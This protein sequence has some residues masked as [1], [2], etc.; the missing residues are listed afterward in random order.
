VPTIH[1][2]TT[3]VLL[4]ALAGTLLLTGCSGGDQTDSVPTDYSAWMRQTSAQMNGDSD[5]GEGGAGGHLSA[6]DGS[7][8]ARASASLEYDLSGPY[9]DLSGPYDVLAVCRSTKMV[10]LTVRDF[11]AERVGNGEDLHPRSVLGEADITCGVTSRIPIDVPTGR[12]GV[13]LDATTT[14]TSGKTLF[15]TVIVTRGTG[16]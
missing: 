5:G 14:D 4:T 16:Q 6:E 3:A 11:T 8:K 10:H 15:N 7:K 9:D 13:M 2:R 1:R 12:A